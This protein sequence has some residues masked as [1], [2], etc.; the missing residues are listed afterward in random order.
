MHKRNRSIHNKVIWMSVL[1]LFVCVCC[2]TYVWA[3]RMEYYQMDDSGAIALTPVNLTEEAV[4]KIEIVA[5]PLVSL[6]PE[7]SS[8]RAVTRYIETIER[9][10]TNPGIE[11]SDDQVIWKSNTEVEIFKS[12]YVNGVNEITV[13]SDNGDSL[14]APGTMN[15]Y[16]FKLKNTGDVALKYTVSVDAFVSPSGIK[17][18][19]VAHLN[20]YD[21]LWISGSADEYVDLSVLDGAEDSDLLSVNCY[22]YYTLDWMWPFESNQDEFDTWLGNHASSEDL[23]L[24]IVINTIAEATEDY[25]LQSGIKV[26]N[27]GDDSMLGIWILLS[28]TSLFMLI[29]L[30]YFKKKS[31]EESEQKK[32]ELNS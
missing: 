15:S 22:A 28:A 8:K 26:P 32:S 12:S 6:S 23:T 29:L 17:I 20:R 16:T 13:N 18:P 27:T 31:D 11:I 9:I 4:E 30:I 21:G 24:T 1:V 14:I 5:E 25:F 3:E 10:P 19:V 7:E 2:T